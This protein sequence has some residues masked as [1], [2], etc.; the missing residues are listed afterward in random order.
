M[1]LAFAKQRYM[2]EYT[3]STTKWHNNTPDTILD[4]FMLRSKNY[5]MVIE[6]EADIWIL[7]DGKRKTGVHKHLESLHPKGIKA[8]YQVQNA[9]RWE[10]VPWHEYDAVICIDSFLEP[11]FM[12]KYPKILWCYYAGEHKAPEYRQSRG[13]P[14][15]GY[16]VFMDH[17]LRVQHPIELGLPI[18]V[19]FPALV[20][21]KAFE[22]VLDITKQKAAFLDSRILRNDKNQNGTRQ[23]LEKQLGVKILAPDAWNYKDSYYEAAHKH[24]M[25]PRAYLERVA[26]CRYFVLMRGST[27]HKDSTSFVGQAAIEAA[28][29]GCIVFSGHG[30]YPNL[31]CHKE[32]YINPGDMQTVATKIQMLEKD[33]GL[34]RKVVAHQHR[35]LKENFWDKPMAL[36]EELIKIKQR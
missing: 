1:K 30:A 12:S 14:L 4:N 7:E 25:S 2:P 8:L 10:S 24:I 20:S 26:K 19:P 33:E 9:F 28:A 27:D 21:P 36:L 16:D 23:N 34:R 32:T 18:S 35:R 17:V 13:S 11:E 15:H 3:W 5:G 29:L 31:L 6:T 22:A